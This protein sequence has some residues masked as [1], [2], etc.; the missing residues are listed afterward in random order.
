MAVVYGDD[1]ERSPAAA[2]RTSLEVLARHAGHCLEALTAARAAQ[3][4]LQDIE[5]LVPEDAGPT[6]PFDEVGDE[7][8]TP[9]A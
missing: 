9:D 4:A 2:W 6:L 5:S 7:R 8:P 1:A 3:L